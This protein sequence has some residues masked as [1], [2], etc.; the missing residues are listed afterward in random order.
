MIVQIHK[1]ELKVASV[2]FLCLSTDLR[3]KRVAPVLIQ[4]IQRRCYRDGVYQAIYTSGSVLP[5]PIS[6]PRQYF[7]RTLNLTKAC[8]TG[9]KDV[10]SGSTFEEEEARLALPENTVIP[11]LRPMMVSDVPRIQELLKKYLGRFDL[12]PI[13]GLNGVCHWFMPETKTG[14]SQAVYTYVVEDPKSSMI[15]DVI[16]FFVL[17]STVLR[18]SKHRE[19]REAYLSYYATEY[20]SMG[21]RALKERLKLLI[22][23]GLVLAKRVCT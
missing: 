8:E 4:E 15:T 18:V 9:F 23:D 22:G 16:S 13:I 12:A 11:N 3:H 1:K 20:A 19:L 6:S 14:E 21:D 10:A 7:H 5:T 2:N 17:A